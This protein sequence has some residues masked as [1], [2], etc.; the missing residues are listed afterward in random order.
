[1]IAH[2]TSPLRLPNAVTVCYRATIT[3]PRSTT[4]PEA[5]S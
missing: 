2:E 5:T 3:R 4:P 1:M